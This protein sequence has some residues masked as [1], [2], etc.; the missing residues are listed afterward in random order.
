MVDLRMS[1]HDNSKSFLVEA[2]SKAIQAESDPNQWKFAIFSLVQAIELSLKERLGRDHSILVYS[3]I[4]KPK[5][6]V[7]LEL[8]LKRLVDISEI[9]ID[10]TDIH[11]VKTAAEWRNRV[12]HFEFEFSTTTLKSVFAKLLGFYGSF[13]QRH[14]GEEIHSILPPPLLEEALRIEEYTKELVARAKKRAKEEEIEDSWLWPCPACGWE[15]FVAQDDINKC[16]VC[17]YT[18]EV[19]QC[20]DCGLVDYASEMRKIYTGNYKGLEAWRYV[21]RDCAEDYGKSYLMTETMD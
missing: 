3:N 17:G 12:V 14:L 15:T 5:H 16:Y 1:L 13:N 6:T 4:D 8:A 18:E 21:C 7:S 11:A 2:L 10:K 20:E 9:A 19:L